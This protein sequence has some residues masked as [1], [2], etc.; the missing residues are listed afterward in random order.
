MTPHENLT[1]IS[2]STRMQISRGNLLNRKLTQCFQ[3]FWFISIDKIAKSKLSEHIQTPAK[4]KP[5]WGKCKTMLP[6][7]RYLNNLD[8]IKASF[9]HFRQC[10]FIQLLDSRLQILRTLTKLS[11]TI[12]TPAIKHII[13]IKCYY[14]MESS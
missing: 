9:D 3:L 4:Y 8:P 13:M 14:M 11:K 2:Y 5:I 12:S 7:T 6:S 1:F 10:L